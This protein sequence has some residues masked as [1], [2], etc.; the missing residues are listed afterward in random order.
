M[1]FTVTN[2]PAAWAA[3]RA[4]VNVT[5]VP[6]A[7]AVPTRRDR[8]GLRGSAGVDRERIAGDHAGDA[9]DLDVRVARVR[10]GRQRRLRG[11]EAACLPRQVDRARPVDRVRR[12]ERGAQ[13]LGDGVRG[14][15][16]THDGVRAPRRAAVGRGERVD[17]RA[18]RIRND[19]AAARRA[20]TARR[21]RRLHERHGS[22]SDGRVARAGGS[23]P[24]LA[25][26]GRG[27]HLELV[28]RA[29][30]RCSCTRGSSC[31]SPCSGSRCRT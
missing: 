4:G 28:R 5:P 15:G 30:S 14:R 22:G 10:R 7:P 20:C 2:A 29:S 6:P 8:H 11:P 17:R 31:R 23:R 9:R 3:A 18:A 12:D 1:P 16:R 26:V 27:Q 21:R 13:A 25:A 24:R 19:D